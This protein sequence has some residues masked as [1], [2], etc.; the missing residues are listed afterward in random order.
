MPGVGTQNPRTKI[1]VTSASL[2]RNGRMPGLRLMH[3]TLNPRRDERQIDRPPYVVVGEI[4]R[5]ASKPKARLTDVRLI[6]RVSG[7]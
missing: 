4:I 7:Y 1:K 2:E 5:I 6:T 3:V